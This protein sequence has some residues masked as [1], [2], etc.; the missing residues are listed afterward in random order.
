MFLNGIWSTVC[1]SGSFICHTDCKISFVDRVVSDVIFNCISLP[2]SNYIIQKCLYIFPKTLIFKAC[3]EDN[4]FLHLTLKI[5]IFINFMLLEPSDRKFSSNSWAPECCFSGKDILLICCTLVF[6]IYW[7]L[8]SWLR[9]PKFALYWGGPSTLLQKSVTGRSYESFQIQFTSLKILLNIILSST[10][11]TPKISLL[12][13]ITTK[14][15]YA[16]L[17]CLIRSTCPGLFFLNLVTLILAGVQIM[18]LF[19]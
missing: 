6:M 11:T 2:I 12:C 5:H 9:H 18:K 10:P 3:D 14:I 19:Q 8:L 15:L 7:M 1:G 16:C 4:L 13:D 17:V